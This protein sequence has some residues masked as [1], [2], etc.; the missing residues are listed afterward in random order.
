MDRRRRLSRVTIKYILNKFPNESHLEKTLK[1][2]WIDKEKGCWFINEDW[3]NYAHV[4]GGERAHRYIFRIY[5]PDKPLGK[6]FVCHK[7][8]RPGCINPS[9]LFTG[10]PTENFQDAVRKGRAQYLKFPNKKLRK[11]LEEL[12]ERDNW[13]QLVRFA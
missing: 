9:H 5:N 2:V 8:D 7:C 12:R 1:R 3:S 10:T 13:K 4:E 6:L 11:E